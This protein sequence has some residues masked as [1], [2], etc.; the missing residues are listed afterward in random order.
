M[1]LISHRRIRRW[2]DISALETKQGGLYSGNF[3][4]KQNSILIGTDSE[5]AQLGAL[6]ASDYKLCR[7]IGCVI[8]CLLADVLKL[9]D[10]LLSQVIYVENHTDCS[11]AVLLFFICGV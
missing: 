9:N 4:K 8:S 3:L 11:Q 10:V 1:L 7:I 6:L 2:E 5:L